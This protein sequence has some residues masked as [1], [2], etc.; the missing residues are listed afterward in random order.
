MIFV[1]SRS[2]IIADNRVNEDGVVALLGTDSSLMLLHTSSIQMRKIRVIVDKGR[3]HQSRMSKGYT[4]WKK[5][6]NI[7]INPLSFLLKIWFMYTF[8]QMFG[9]TFLKSFPHKQNFFLK[10]FLWIFFLSS[11]LIIKI[12]DYW[13]LLTY[14]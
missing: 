3:V 6:A 7:N 12:K 8:I 1:L 10:A 13:A 9:Q 14:I 2:M 11:T 5:K 4:V